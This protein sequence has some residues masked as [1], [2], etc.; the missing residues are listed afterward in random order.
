MKAFMLMIFNAGCGRHREAAVTAGTLSAKLAS[1][2]A[3]EQEGTVYGH[4]GQQDRAR[5]DVQASLGQDIEDWSLHS[6][7]LLYH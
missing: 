1:M 5:L 3:D 6:G 7:G 2:E 4:T